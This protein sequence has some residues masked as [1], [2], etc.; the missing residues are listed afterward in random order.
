MFE[1]EAEEFF[2]TVRQVKSQFS[3]I[4]IK[5]NPGGNESRGVGHPQIYEKCRWNEVNTSGC[6]TFEYFYMKID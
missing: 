2:D 4:K 1:E 5:P 3:H 6:P